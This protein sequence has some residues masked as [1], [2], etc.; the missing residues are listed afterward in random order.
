MIFISLAGPIVASPAPSAAGRSTLAGAETPLA[1]KAG[2]RE[3]KS[4]SLEMREKNMNATSRFPLNGKTIAGLILIAVGILFALENLGWIDGFSIWEFWPL[5]LIFVGI[6]HVV[7]PRQPGHRTWGVLEIAVG[8]FFLLRTLGVFWISFWKVWPAMLVIAGAHLIWQ[9]WSNRR[10]GG[11]GIGERAHDGAMAGLEA[12]RGL[13]EGSPAARTLEE[14]AVFGGGDRVIRTD[15]FRGG[16]VNVIF[17]GFDIDLREAVMLGDSAVIDVFVC[18]GGLDLRV[19]EEW[20]VINQVTPIFG[21]SEYKPRP[22]GPVTAGS[23]RK[24]LTI[25]G[26]VIFGG[27][28]VKN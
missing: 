7:R 13:R 14:V 16:S 12:T 17:G 26:A 2:R 9:A 18:F 6:N 5:I 24:T 27:V 4:R 21:S 3:R 23:A 20:S 28:E 1:E 11:P 19:P 22:G 10:A 8:L 15:D 25:T